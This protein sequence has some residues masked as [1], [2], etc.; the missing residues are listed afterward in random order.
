MTMVIS[1][2]A[3]KEVLRQQQ[4]QFEKSQINLLDN[5]DTAVSNDHTKRR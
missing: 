1:S 4:E 5:T 2:D 3:L